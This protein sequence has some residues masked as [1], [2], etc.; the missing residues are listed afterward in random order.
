M[1]LGTSDGDWVVNAILSSMKFYKLLRVKR[2]DLRIPQILTEGTFVAQLRSGVALVSLQSLAFLTRLNRVVE[3]ALNEALADLGQEELGK[4]GCSTKDLSTLDVDL[5]ARHVTTEELSHA[6]G[7]QLEGN[8]I[9]RQLA[10]S[11]P[12]PWWDRACD[13]GLIIGTFTYGLHSYRAMQ[14]DHDLPFQKKVCGA[15]KDDYSCSQAY[16]TFLCATK[17]ARN[18]FDK[19]L[20]ISQAK[21]AAD[22]GIA[23][24]PLANE[25]AD[26]PSVQEPSKVTSNGDS[27]GD[28]IKLEK[29]LES[30]TQIDDGI[31]TISCL[32]RNIHQAVNEHIRKIRKMSEENVSD[33]ARNSNTTHEM[34]PM[35]DSRCL[36]A[37]VL[38]LIDLIENPNP[39]KSLACGA[40]MTIQNSTGLK[41]QA[42]KKRLC[43]Y[44]GVPERGEELLRVPFYGNA[45]NI[46]RTILD[47]TSSYLLGAASENL[48]VISTPHESLKYKRG[49]GVPSILTRYGM[50]ALLYTDTSTFKI[51]LD[52]EEKRLKERE[53]DNLVVDFAVIRN[54]DADADSAEMVQGELRSYYMEHVPPILM[55]DAVQRTGLCGA[56]LCC[57]YSLPTETTSPTVPIQA[58]KE[59]CHFDSFSFFSIT[60]LLEVASQIIGSHVS[61]SE[62]GAILYIKNVLI[63]HCTRACLMSSDSLDGTRVSPHIKTSIESVQENT[64]LPDPFLPLSQQSGE[65]IRN[66]S[67][68]LRRMK[69]ATTIQ[70]LLGEGGAI[71]LTDLLDF[72]KSP[73]MRNYTDGVPLWW[74][75]WIHD[76]ALL[77]HGARFGLLSIV[78]HHQDRLIVESSGGGETS[79]DE[80]L[81]DK[82]EVEKHIKRLLFEDDNM[83]NLNLGHNSPGKRLLP[84]LLIEKA[85][86][87][88]LQRLVDGLIK[89][90]PSSHV[91]E[92]RIGFMCG[93]LLRTCRDE[94]TKSKCSLDSSTSS[95]FVDFPMFDHGGWPN[96]GQRLSA[97]I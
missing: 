29:T 69:M 44:L 28:V 10:A 6:I 80:G 70:L 5:K 36:D 85:T 82:L 78:R 8:W 55:N 24:N 39:K 57:G 77:A 51:F 96:D 56:L 2:R 81:F 26:Q 11:R 93:E 31:V 95:M 65:A 84:K 12:A 74:C 14:N 3:H 83:D 66:A 76:L 41:K 50:I 21:H 27:I 30:K 38:K 22:E 1:F 33:S 94:M 61:F 32:S 35:P 48:A 90:F 20:S 34:L 63:P 92:R 45:S 58:L 62:E 64:H 87:L 67:A 23:V 54:D 49:P 9:N 52:I 47:G 59:L 18:T 4:R 72:L 42:V 19:A 40:E 53:R 88:E 7:R 37:R 43:R 71:E 91:I 75:P 16:Q 13:L 97:L 17:A 25:H 46:N 86:T 68:L 60:N 79:T 15:T 73:K 89:Q